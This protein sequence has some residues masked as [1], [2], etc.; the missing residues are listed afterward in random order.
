MLVSGPRKCQS[1]QFLGGG[2]RFWAIPNFMEA[3]LNFVEAKLSFVENEGG[4]LSY[5][6]CV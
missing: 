3:L 5:Q 1:S 6:F 2:L 4:D